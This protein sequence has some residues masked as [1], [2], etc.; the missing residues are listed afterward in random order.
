MSGYTRKTLPA[1]RTLEVPKVDW[2]AVVSACLR[3]GMA[4]AAIGRAVGVHKDFICALLS[5][6]R[7]PKYSTGQRLL[8]LATYAEAHSTRTKHKLEK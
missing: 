4:K 6:K 3:H 8:L 1:P 5:G 7:E 2:C